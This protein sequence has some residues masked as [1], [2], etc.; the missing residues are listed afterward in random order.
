M[1]WELL[2]GN[3]LFWKLE[4]GNTTLWELELE[5]TLLRELELGNT[6]LWELKL[7]ITLFWELK[8]GTKRCCGISISGS[9]IVL[10]E[11]NAASSATNKVWK[12]FMGN[13]RFVK[14]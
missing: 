1:L 12:L 5:N 9:L 6:M 3:T 13:Q 14:H 10:W 2:L 4:L 8:L 11:L 7:G